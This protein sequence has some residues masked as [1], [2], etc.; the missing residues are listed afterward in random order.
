[1]LLLTG[2]RQIGKTTLLEKIANKDR[3]Y[4]TLRDPFIRLLA[5]EEPSLFLQRYTP[6]IIIDEIQYAPNLLPYI[7]IYVHRHK[8]NGDFWFITSQMFQEVSESLAGRVGIIPMQGLSLSEIQG[9]K[10]EP[11]NFDIKRLINRLKKSKKMNL[12]EIYHI[13]HKGS[14]PALY[15]NKQSIERYYASY[16]DAYI[17]RD[18]KQFTEVSNG[19]DFYKFLVAC[20]ARTSQMLNYSDIAKDVGVS[21]PTIKKWISLLCLN[22]ALF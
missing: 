2:P 5:N 4:I 14:M 21:A 6:P 13:I 17:N 1:M 18:I 12:Q 20:A 3:T 11:Y 7:K 10:N 22:R 16:V 15:K 9:I 8:K 19:L